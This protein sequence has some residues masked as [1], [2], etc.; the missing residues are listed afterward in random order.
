MPDII[1]LLPDSVANQIAAGE[2]IQ[3]PASVIKELMENAVDAGADKI[4]IIVKNAGKTSIQISDNGCGMSETDAR[5]SFERHATSKIRSAN[6]LFA[7][8][9]M[10]FRGEALASIAAISEVTMR[11]RRAEDELGTEIKISGSEVISQEPV[12]CPAGTTFIIKN[13]FFNVPARRKFLKTNSTEFKHI[14]NEFHR[15]AM[16]CPNLS[17]SLDHDNAEIYNLPQGNK[18]QRIVHLFGKNINQNLVSVNTETSIVKLT[19]YIGKPEN[20]KKTFGEQFFFVNNRYMRHPYFH[21]AVM[22]A[23]SKILHADTFPSYFIF[24]DIDPDRIDINIHPTKT[25]IKFEDERS[26]WQILHAAVRESLGRFNVIPTIDFDGDHKFDIPVIKRNTEFR[27]P[28]ISVNQ[29]YN[30]FREEKKKEGSFTASRLERD[31]LMNWEKLYHDFERVPEVEGTENAE[32]RGEEPF[33]PGMDEDR[34]QSQFMQLKG[35]FILSPVKSGLMIIDQRR[36]HERILYERFLASLENAGSVSQKDLFPRAIELGAAEY[37]LLTEI[38]DDLNKLGFDIREL[39]NNSI[40]VNG[41]PSMLSNHDPVKV[42]QDFITEYVNTSRDVKISA[43]EKMAQ[44]LSKTSAIN[45]GKILM[46]E[47]MQEM[48]DQLFA[49]KEPGF[50]PGGLPVLQIITL[51]ELTKRFGQL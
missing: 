12:S 43:H 38:A 25:E 11:T 24:F 30:P 40:A 32:N 5:L 15:V 4:Q 7:I 46:L 48:V 2:V 9:T 44:S 39:G 31:N 34:K 27:V 20:A 28:G 37:V 35:K 49:C 8:R 23:Y 22:E 18:R 6:D 42:L 45:Y 1:Q 16:A 14:L 13:L 17:L 3:R 19:G 50:T 33:L 36:A 21:R 41:Y 47:E 26:I 10:G 29:D 51:N